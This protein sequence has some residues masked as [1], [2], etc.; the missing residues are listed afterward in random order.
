MKTQL[1]ILTLFVLALV[2]SVEGFKKRCHPQCRWQ[3][4]KK[5]CPVK[6]EPKCSKPVCAS[7]CQELTSAV[8]HINCHAPECTTVCPNK[9]CE[10]NHCPECK[11]ECK[12]SVCDTTCVPPKASCHPVCNKPKC[13]WN[14][15]YPTAR[16]CTEP[17][18][19]LKCD[20]PNCI[21]K[22]KC[23]PCLDGGKIV[24]LPKGF[25]AEDEKHKVCCEC[26]KVITEARK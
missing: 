13:K 26:P 10:L 8:C 17:K 22:T 3:C 6:C 25:F 20:H 9:W 18:C 7:S 5:K 23:C 2:N 11:I 16:T 4:Q 24:S 1:V 15:F 14:C 21:P 19:E 12:P